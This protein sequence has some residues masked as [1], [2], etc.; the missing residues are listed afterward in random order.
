MAQIYMCDKCGQ[1]TTNIAAKMVIYP[2]T[3]AASPNLDYVYKQAI[4]MM[5]TSF[6]LCIDCANTM[7]NERPS[8]KILEQAEIVK[9]L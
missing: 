8:L 6:D 5:S 1:V 4:D 3:D 2:I 9:D 7:L